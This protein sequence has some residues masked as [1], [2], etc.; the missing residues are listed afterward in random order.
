MSEVIYLDTSRFS[1]RRTI[2]ATPASQ[3]GPRIFVRE[4]SSTLWLV[5]DEDDSKGGCFR[6]L[7]TAFRFVEEQFGSEAEVVVQPRFPTQARKTVSHIRQSASV[8]H[9]AITAH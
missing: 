1:A 8:A 2:E 9:K 6:S 5:H 4:V 3:F 7:Q